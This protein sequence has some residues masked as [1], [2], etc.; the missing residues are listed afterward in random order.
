MSEDLLVTR[1]END[2]L[3]PRLVSAKGTLVVSPLRRDTAVVFGLIPKDTTSDTRLTEQ[4]PMFPTRSRPTKTTLGWQQLDLNDAGMDVLTAPLL[5]APTERNT[6]TDGLL[7]IIMIMI[8]IM[9]TLFKS[10]IIL[11]E[12]ECSTNWGDCKSNQVK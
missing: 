11:A 2:P 6:R 12:H 10:Q 5:K 1:N 8:M 9:I 3:E 4:V 7:M